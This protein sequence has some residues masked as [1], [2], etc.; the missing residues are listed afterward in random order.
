MHTKIVNCERG[1]KSVMADDSK[2]CVTSF[3]TIP[4]MLTA[5]PE[6]TTSQ[7]DTKRLYVYVNVSRHKGWIS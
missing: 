3:S 6:L 4:Y 7:L 5:F 2:L 1:G